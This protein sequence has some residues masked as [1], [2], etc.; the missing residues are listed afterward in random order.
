[1]RTDRQGDLPVASG[2]AAAGAAAAAVVADEDV[3]GELDALLAGEV[4]LL[5]HR[6]RSHSR[7]AEVVAVMAAVVAAEVV[8]VLAGP[9]PSWVRSRRLGDVAGAARA[10]L[11]AALVVAA[12]AAVTSQPEP[13]GPHNR[14]RK[15]GSRR[16][17]TDAR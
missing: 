3:A 8:G 7:R 4:V 2:V 1:M 5:K 15:A 6:S 11:A 14:S 17:S 9:P 10:L 16:Q 12:V 13:E